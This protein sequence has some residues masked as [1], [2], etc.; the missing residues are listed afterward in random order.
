MVPPS[1]VA[2]I[3]D[4]SVA[5][6]F[7]QFMVRSAI[8]P[9]VSR[10]TSSS[11]LRGSV[12]STCMTSLQKPISFILFV[13]VSLWPVPM[14]I[15]VFLVIAIIVWLNTRS[16]SW[17]SLATALNPAIR[18]YDYAILTGM[19]L[20]LIPL[21]WVGVAGMWLT[22]SAWPMAIV[23]VGVMLAGREEDS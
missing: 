23:G 13:L 5:G 12:A 3:E 17:P 2:N 7:T 19:G 4:I 10:A 20:W 8:L 15:G 11:I 21:S 14:A 16:V 18:A 9:S 1:F 22:G 6:T